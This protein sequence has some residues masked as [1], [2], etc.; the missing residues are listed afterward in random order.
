MN[1][2]KNL[3]CFKAYD[4][5]GTLGEEIHEDI[6]YKIGRAIVQSLKAKTLVMGFDARAT[7]PDLA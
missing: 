3:T 5:R 4:I 2:V 7:S 6:A 1:S